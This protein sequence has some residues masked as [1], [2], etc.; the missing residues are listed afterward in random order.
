MLLGHSLVCYLLQLVDYESQCTPHLLCYCAGPVRT[1]SDSLGNKP[2]PTKIIPTHNH[3]ISTNPQPPWLCANKS[4]SLGHG[5]SS[6]SA[7]RARASHS[8]VPLRQVGSHPPTPM[9]STH[10]LLYMSSLTHTLTYSLLDFQAE[11]SV[12]RLQDQYGFWSKWTE[13]SATLSL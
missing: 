6:C 13:L 1:K 3:T 12:V 11:H 4:T 8:W 5:G 10:S 7:W 9:H 2:I